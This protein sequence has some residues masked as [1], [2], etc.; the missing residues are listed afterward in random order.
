MFVRTLCGDR[1]LRSHELSSINTFQTEKAFPHGSDLVVSAQDVT[2]LS[3]QPPKRTRA[4]V[5]VLPARRDHS[6]T[7]IDYESPNT[8]LSPSENVPYRKPY[9]DQRNRAIQVCGCEEDRR[10]NGCSQV[11]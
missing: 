10:R 4:Y 2:G 5:S 3:W 9:K 8:Y 11:Q 7:V 1:L 6:C